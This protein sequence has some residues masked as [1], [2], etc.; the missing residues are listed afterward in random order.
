MDK[1]SDKTELM[2]INE[3]RNKLPTSITIANAQI[4]S[5][6]SEEDIGFA[7]CCHPSMS[8]HVTIITRTTTSNYVIWNLF[9]DS[10]QIRQLPHLCLFLFYKKLNA[11]LYS[12]LILH[13][14]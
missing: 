13:M 6:Q 4:P 2:L 5:K 9:E 10:K 14:M 8:E 11:V 3:K 1:L 7:L 12:C